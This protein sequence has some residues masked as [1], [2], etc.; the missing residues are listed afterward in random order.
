MWNNDGDQA[1]LRNPE[2]KVIDRCSYDGSEGGTA[3][4]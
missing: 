1:Q 2:G 4:C 3:L